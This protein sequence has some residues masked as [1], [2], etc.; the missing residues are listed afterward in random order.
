[1]ELVDDSF[2]ENVAPVEIDSTT[3]NIAGG[4]S[5]R[6]DIGYSTMKNKIIKQ[7]HERRLC[8]RFS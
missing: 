8:F 3:P 6:S 2:E 4:A 7:R 5:L 1:M